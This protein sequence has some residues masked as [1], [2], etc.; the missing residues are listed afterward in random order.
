[1]Q[2]IVDWPG[3][4]VERTGAMTMSKQ[5]NLDEQYQFC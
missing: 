2:P 1:M 5:N 3:L 4:S